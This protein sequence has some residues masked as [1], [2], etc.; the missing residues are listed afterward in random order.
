MRQAAERLEREGN[1]KKHVPVSSHTQ[2]A[3]YLLTK[4]NEN[5]FLA[6]KNE[7]AFS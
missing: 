3:R 4:I 2:L 5:E 6:N 7:F 1:K